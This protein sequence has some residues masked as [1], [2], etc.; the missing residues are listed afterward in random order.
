MESLLVSHLDVKELM[1]KCSERSIVGGDGYD[2]GFRG[3]Q[4]STRQAKGRERKR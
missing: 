1:F 2:I 3:Q 4:A